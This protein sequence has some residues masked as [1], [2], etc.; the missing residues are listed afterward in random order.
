MKQ[1]QDNDGVIYTLDEI[2]T[3][4]EN[5]ELLTPE[6]LAELDALEIGEQLPVDMGEWFER[7]Q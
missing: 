6:E 3:L 1:L 4:N 7:I 2:K 5:E